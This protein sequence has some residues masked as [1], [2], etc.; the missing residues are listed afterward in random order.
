[1]VFLGV[2]TVPNE[3]LQVIGG[4]LADSEAAWQAAENGISVRL[5]EMRPKYTTPAHRTDLL[6]ELVC[7]NSLRA[8]G[9]ENAVGLLK[10]E[11]RRLGSLVMA[12]ADETRVEAGGALAVDRNAFARLITE[13]VQTYP[14]IAVVRERVT[15]LPAGPTIVASGP[16]TAEPLAAAIQ[17]AHGQA[18][19]FFTMP[20]PRSSRPI[21][22]T[23]CGICRFPLPKRERC[24]F[25]LST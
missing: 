17:K 24:L 5:F 19:L 22:L 2:V 18:H 13:K 23:G 16:L 20:W 11:M 9:L 8:A 1:M 21:R 12:A 25:E 15:E 7:S 6:A 4:G 14:L 10:E 3:V